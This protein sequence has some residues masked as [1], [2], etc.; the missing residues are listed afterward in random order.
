MS[1]PVHLEG[2][3]D[4]QES[5]WLWLVKWILVIPHYV[6]L[7]LLWI[8]FVLMSVEALGADESY[9]ARAAA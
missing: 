4:Q 9:A 5:R 6:V 7:V 2:T 8:A 3:L 1:A